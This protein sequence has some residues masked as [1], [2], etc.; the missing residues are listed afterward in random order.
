MAFAFSPAAF[1]AGSSIAARIAMIA[2]T[3]RSSISVKIR[4]FTLRSKNVEPGT[5]KEEGRKHW[6]N[7]TL[8]QFNNG[9][10]E[11]EEEVRSGDWQCSVLPC[12][13]NEIPLLQLSLIRSLISVKIRIFTL[14]SKNLEQKT[15]KEEVEKHW[16][17]STMEQ[18]NN[19]RKK[20]EAGSGD[21][22]CPALPY[23]RNEI[24]L[25]QLFLMRSSIK[26][27][28]LVFTLRSKKIE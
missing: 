19:G 27:K 13:R 20:E 28:I 5:R 24:L 23:R 1:S 14:R 18:F 21:W 10:K 17:N 22:Q 4:I 7:R 26:L 16:N 2:I 8:E 12:C 3:M 15:R 6:N 9:K 11:G 25:L